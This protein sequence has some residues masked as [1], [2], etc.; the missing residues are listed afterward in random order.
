MELDLNLLL[1]QLAVIFLPGIIW[2]RLDARFAAKIKPSTWES[3][4]R[5]LSFGL[6]VYTVEF[7]IYSAFNLHFTTADLTNAKAENVITKPVIFE[8][9]GALPLSLGLATVWLYA[10]RHKWISRFLQKIGATKKFGDED[11]WDYTFNSS[12]PDVEYVHVRDFANGYLYA[13][14]VNIFSETDR[15]RELVLLNVIVY[16]LNGVEQYQVPRLYIAR[17]QEN[18]HIEFPYTTP[19]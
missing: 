15:L 3:L 13:G 1:V 17:P 19:K 4:V 10:A 8:I 18:M 9:V 7:M 12:I 2:E 11:V 14:W 5:T 16:D 6:V